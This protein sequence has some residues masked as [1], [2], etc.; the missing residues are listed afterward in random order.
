MRRAKS[1]NVRFE[2]DPG[3]GQG[4][5]R[6]HTSG[7]RPVSAEHVPSAG[8]QRSDQ[9]ER[10]AT[11]TMLRKKP[12]DTVTGGSANTRRA[13]RADMPQLH[14]AYNETNQRAPSSVGGWHTSRLCPHKS[15]LPGVCAANIL[16]PL[17]ARK[18]TAVRCSF[19]ASSRC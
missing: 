16:S 15:R 5:E 1:G 7:R 12:A 6:Q 18:A 2:F 4:D 3:W 8:A 19:N 13:Q 9:H 14:Q 11:V 10:Q 17:L